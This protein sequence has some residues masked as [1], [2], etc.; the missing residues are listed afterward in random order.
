M[1]CQLATS[2]FFSYF[3]L[4]VNREVNSVVRRLNLVLHNAS[5]QK[6]T[7]NCFAPGNGA[8]LALQAPG[9]SWS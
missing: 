3:W 6:S 5:L 4:R 9:G 7:D 8:L 2:T 1:Q